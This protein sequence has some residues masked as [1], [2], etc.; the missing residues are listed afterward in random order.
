MAEEDYK[1]ELHKVV[2]VGDGGVGKSA[3]TIQLTQGHF[4]I[5]YDPTIENCYRKTLTVDNRICVLDILDTAGQEEYASMLDQ[6]FRNGHGFLIVYSVTDRNSFESIKNYQ[7]KILRVKEA[8]SFP[9]VFVANKV[10]LVKDRDVSEKE[11]KDK[12]AELGVKYIET[13]AKNKLNIEEAFYTLVR[14]IRKQQNSDAPEE[15]GKGGPKKQKE[16]K[17]CYL[18]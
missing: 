5:D 12:A 7:N 6:Y 10:D 13:S 17:K 14:E 1:V 3:I 9:I 15:A 16:K 2:L 11:G 18:F 4:I 8:T